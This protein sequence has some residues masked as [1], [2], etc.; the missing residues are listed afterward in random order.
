MS[1]VNLRNLGIPRNQPEDIQVLFRTRRPGKGHLGHSGGWQETEGNHT[2]SSIHLPIKQKPQIKGLEGYGSI[3]SAPPTPQRS[4]PMEHGQQEVQPGITL[5]I[6]LRKL[7][8][9]MSQQDTFQRSY[10]NNQR[11]ESQQAVQTPG[12]EGNQDKG[13]SSNYSHCRRR[14][15]PDRAYYHSFSLTKSGATQLSSGFTL[16][17]HKQ[18]SG[19]ES[20]FFTIPGSFQEKTRIQREE[21]DLFQPQAARVRLNDAEAV[22]L[23]ERSTQEPIIVVNT[24][25]ISSPINRTITPTQNEHNFVTPEMKTQ[26]KFDELHRSNERFKQLKTLHENT[27]KAIQEICAE[28]RKASEK[29]NKRLSQFFEEQYHFKG[30]RDLL[31]QD[32]IKWLNVCQQR[33]PQEQGHSFD[34]P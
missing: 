13:K 30:D 20:P 31:D 14:I 18:I 12:W 9:D 19:Q 24:S 28:L 7:P 23:G 32:I 25:I 34:N 15:E 2:H 5:G 8:T 33:K 21:Q 17:R 3:S 16:F 6:A 29:T 26:E 1:P 22:L 4:I 27:I 10:G 11:M